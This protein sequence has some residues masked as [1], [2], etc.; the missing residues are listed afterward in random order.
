MVTHQKLDGVNENFMITQED[1]GTGKV[2][3][4]YVYFREFALKFLEYLC[5]HFEVII[6]TR[7]SP[8]I[9]NLVIDTIK[10]MRD[11]IEFDMVIA[12]P[13]YCK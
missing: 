11:K 12:G 2:N 6:Y 5:Q 10:S 1:K 7:L 9:T 13:K 4:F 3:T 8:S